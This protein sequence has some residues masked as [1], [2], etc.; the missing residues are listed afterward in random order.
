MLTDE[1]LEKLTTDLE[2]D[3]VERKE[4]LKGS[5]K[6]KVGEAICAFANDLPR[7]SKVGVIFIGL[8]DDGSPSGLEITDQ[9]LQELGAFQRDGNILP[10]PSLT[11][12]KRRIQGVDV[13]VVLVEPS[14]ETPVRY[15]GRMWIRVGPRR[16]I[17]G[18]DDERILTEKRQAGN[19]KFD[20]RPARNASLA[21]LDLDTFEEKYLP[22]AVAPEI[23]EQ[24]ERTVEERLS[25]LQLMLP[26][27]RP[28]FGALL[29]LGKYPRKWLPGAYV[30]FARFDG[31]D[32]LAPILDQKEI[33]GPLPRVIP[34]LDHLTMLNIQVATEIGSHTYEKRSPDYPA[35]AIQQLLRNA[36]LHRSYEID[37]PVYWYWF[38]DRIEIHSP[39]GLY[40]RVNED[41]FR[42]GITD[43]RNPTLA[44]GLKVLNFVQRFGVGI[45]MAFKLCEENG[46]PPPEFE[47][48]PAAVF[49]RIHRSA[50]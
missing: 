28:T 20:E 43:Y 17:A 7:N 33:D 26:D 49:V 24:N 42:S 15:E 5:A 4:S 23:L 47:F 39:G 35:G 27:G 37:A 2:S 18:K 22:R 12:Q 44:Q 6:T 13:A 25:S 1:E 32:P 8:K 19:F 30:Q 29:L 10:I 21:D 45:K 14:A 16:S 11:V 31:D 48:A 9:L 50:L 40:G 41:N 34:D 46:N 3:R 38:R 36:V